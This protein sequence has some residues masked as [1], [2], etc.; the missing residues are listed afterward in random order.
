MTA[1]IIPEFRIFAR[2]DHP[3]IGESVHE[4]M[5]KENLFKNTMYI[6]DVVEW[7]SEKT[8]VMLEGVIN[9]Y[10]DSMF[11]FFLDDGD[12][13]EVDTMCKKRASKREKEK[14]KEWRATDTKEYGILPLS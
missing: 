11:T 2:Y 13:F 6:V 7:T 4:R 1:T 3:K 12:V 5:A 14:I 8:Y 9:R 10:P